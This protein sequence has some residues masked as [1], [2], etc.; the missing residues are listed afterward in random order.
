MTVSVDLKVVLRDKNEEVVKQSNFNPYVNSA[1]IYQYNYPI[2][3]Q[4]STSL[5]LFSYSSPDN[6]YFPVA[7]DLMLVKNKGNGTVTIHYK[8]LY[9][10]DAEIDI[11]S[12][13]LALV[14][15]VDIVGEIW[16]ENVSSYANEVEI[17]LAGH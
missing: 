11:K 4:A 13:K 12:G 3:I 2:Q 16:L 7:A 10:D 14:Q 17:F 1:A 15:D 8:N 9:G 6:M 5:V